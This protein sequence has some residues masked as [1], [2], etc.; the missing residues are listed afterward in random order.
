MEIPLK[1]YKTSNGIYFQ[2]DDTWKNTRIDYKSEDEF[3]NEIEN[4]WIQ[5]KHKEDIDKLKD[6]LDKDFK[7]IKEKEENDL[8]S[9]FKNKF[10]E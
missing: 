6:V 4:K 1:F 10:T 2:Y 7:S 9:Y 8:D 5:L 3:K